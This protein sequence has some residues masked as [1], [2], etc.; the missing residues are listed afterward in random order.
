MVES[1]WG[2]L[3]LYWVCS[4][5]NFGDCWLS[6]WSRIF[7]QYCN[8]L[9]ELIPFLV[10]HGQSWNAY[11]HLQKL[12][13]WCSCWWCSIHQE[14]HG[15]ERNLNEWKLWCNYIT[16]ALELDESKLIRYGW[17]LILVFLIFW[18]SFFFQV[19]WLCLLKLM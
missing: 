15:N 13:Q 7:F 18:L 8:Y 19:W 3:F 6:Y 10:W 11:K 5:T 4:P 16:W 9:H 14:I 12:A 1:P 2:A 17:I